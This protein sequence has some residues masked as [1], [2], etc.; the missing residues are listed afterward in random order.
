MV[1]TFV[2]RKASIIS[3]KRRIPNGLSPARETTLLN[4]VDR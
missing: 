1:M 2:V 3:S 4:N